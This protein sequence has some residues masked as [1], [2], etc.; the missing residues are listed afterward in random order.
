MAILYELASDGLH[1][2]SDDE[3]VEIFDQ[4]RAIFEYVFG[5]MK[6]E[7]EEAKKFVTSMADLMQEGGK[8]A[9]ALRPEIK[10]G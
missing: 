7:V 5:K 1:A 3:C 9:A 4:C 6:I 10:K 2:K 8:A